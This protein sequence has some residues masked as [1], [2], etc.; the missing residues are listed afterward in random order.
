MKMD[1]KLEGAGTSGSV[2]RRSTLAADPSR[3]GLGRLDT[4]GEESDTGREGR[5]SCLVGNVVEGRSSQ[6]SAGASD[7]GQ[8]HNG[9][10]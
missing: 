2:P 6:I 10:V 1:C 3:H 9:M 5:V 7:L 4:E 8:S